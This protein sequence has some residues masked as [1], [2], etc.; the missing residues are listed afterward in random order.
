[1]VEERAVPEEE[2]VAVWA[3]GSEEAGATE[4]EA[5]AAEE[6]AERAAVAGEWEGA[7]VRA[8]DLAVEVNET[9]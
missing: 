3:A 7:R 9:R 4:E 6:E 1:V 5:G 2:W 8:A